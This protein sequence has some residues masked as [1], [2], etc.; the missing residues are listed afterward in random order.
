[1]LFWRRRH[2]GW[3]AAGSVTFV[4]A[5]PIKFQEVLTELVESSPFK[6]NRKPIWQA[7]N[8]TSAAL[9]QYLQGQAR[10]RLEVLVALA[11]FFGVTLDYLLLGREAP[12]ETDESRSVARYVDWALADVQAKVGKQAWLTTR[13]GAILADQVKIA[14]EEA[15]AS[16]PGFAGMATDDELLALERY[17]TETRI[18]TRHLAYN[19][20]SVGENL[21]AARFGH[22][23]AA[24]LMSNPGRPYQFLLPGGE[25]RTLEPL[26]HGFTR[27]LRDELGVTAERLRLFCSFRF[28]DSAFLSGGC[29][30][31][32]DRP[33]LEREQPAVA[34]AFERY[35]NEHGWL[36]YSMHPNAET[37]G[38][39]LYGVDQ[40]PAGLEAFAQM[41]SLAHTL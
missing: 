22:S 24:N 21:A 33:A 30:Y 11:D 13:V 35:I 12:R 29:F 23:V 37:T 9:S 8:I 10:P 6:S 4:D 14:V 38:D 17:S 34:L 31:R 5:S 27:L 19:V 25:R 28:T 41:W 18:F 16:D 26:I 7:L 36:G 15:V 3:T 2:S 40:V 1:M 20:I 39:V 32:L